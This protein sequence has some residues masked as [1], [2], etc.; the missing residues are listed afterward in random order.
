LSTKGLGERE[1]SEKFERP[2][3][4]AREGAPPTAVF[5]ALRL[6]I[7]FAI[8]ISGFCHPTNGQQIAFLR[9]GHLSIFSACAS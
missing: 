6:A 1:R 5:H 9:P 7:A 8:P 4:D 2:I 3:L